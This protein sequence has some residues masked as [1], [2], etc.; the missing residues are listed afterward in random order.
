MF[1]TAQ[2]IHEASARTNGGI[3]YD[4]R[5]DYP[6]YTVDGYDGYVLTYDGAVSL[7]NFYEQKIKDEGHIFSK[8]NRPWS[9]I[10]MSNKL[11]PSKAWI[12]FEFETGF[13][14]EDARRDVMGWVWDNTMHSVMDHEGSGHHPV[15]ITFAPDYLENYLERKSDMHRLY[16]YITK[17]NYSLVPYTFAG[18]HANISIPTFRTDGAWKITYIVSVLNYALQTLDRMK[19][20]GRD[21]YGWAYVADTG[22]HIELKLFMSGTD[23]SQFDSYVRMTA[24]ITEAIE[25]LDA[26]WL[27]TVTHQSMGSSWC[28]TLRT[29]K[30]A[31]LVEK[32][33][34]E[35]KYG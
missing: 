25:Y 32:F 20:F 10:N 28:D 16:A 4:P 21:P 5:H 24:A 8:S 11:D 1:A 22:V 27:S 12:G 19:A 6:P 35:W 14:T 15:E 2:E 26:S 17:K 31:E 34:K 3:I 9:I 23:V 30:A 29:A 18:T 33:F 7:L 13:E